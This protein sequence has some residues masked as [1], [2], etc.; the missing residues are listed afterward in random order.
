MSRHVAVARIGI[1]GAIALAL[2]SAIACDDGSDGDPLSGDG[3]TWMYVLPVQCAGNAWEQ[4]GL[5]VEEYYEGLGI[6]IHDI[7]SERFADNV[8]LACSCPTGER[9]EVRVIKAGEEPGQGV[10]YLD[11]GTMVV[12]ES[13]RERINQTVVVDVTSV[14]QTSAGRMVFGKTEDG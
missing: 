11:D 9:I 5:S 8:C 13:G 1:G 4:A 3:L 6:T 12:I 2:L 14:L 10:G 7:R